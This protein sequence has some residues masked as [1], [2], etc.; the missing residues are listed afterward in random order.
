[1]EWKI[2]QKVYRLR[3][4]DVYATIM[5]IENGVVVLAY[6]PAGLGSGMIASYRLEE[7][8][9]FWTTEAPVRGRR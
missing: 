1:M 9:D 6:P 3:T 5:Q 7:M 4:E 2:N 8:G